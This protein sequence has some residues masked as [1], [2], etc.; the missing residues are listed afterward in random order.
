MLKSMLARLDPRTGG[1]LAAM[2]LLTLCG[3]TPAHA[4]EIRIGGTGSALG[5][6]RLL[7]A[8]Y[9]RSHPEVGITVLPSVGSRGGIKAAVSGAL[10]LG[11]SARPLTEDEIKAGAV[12]VEYGRTPLVFAADPRTRTS[13]LAMQDLVDIYSGRMERW[14]D[15]TRIRLV[16]RPMQD[17]DNEAI[18]SLSPAMREAV[19]A[20]QQR[21]GMYI[22]VSD[23][24]AADS[25]EKIPGALGPSSL[26]QILSEKRKVKVL[27]LN[28][29]APDAN[30]IADGTYPLYK[31]MLL[32][33]GPKASP[34]AQAFV[35]F[36]RSEAGREI[37]RQ[38]GHWV[39]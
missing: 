27:A 37:L 35:A 19:R 11:L 6:M 4:E 22:A 8:A 13:G 25:I 29:V 23:Q 3:A 36:V 33:T 10:Q 1:V 15:G 31:R 39:N 24:D 17:T 34:A 21:T 14:P 5:T 38:T 9:T 28:G 7:A 16:L 32:V 26:A 30:S 12:G 20:A 18:A 2:A